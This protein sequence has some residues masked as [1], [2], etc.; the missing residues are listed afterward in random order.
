MSKI[1]NGKTIPSIY[2]LLKIGNLLD[3]ELKDFFKKIRVK[4]DP[5]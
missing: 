3:V 2:T 1:E 4:D 5:A